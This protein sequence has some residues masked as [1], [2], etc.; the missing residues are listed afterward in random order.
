V[1]IYGYPKADGYLLKI[2]P[3]EADTVIRI[4]SLFGEHGYSAKKIVNILNKELKETGHPKPPRGQ[5][6]CVSSLLGGRK[7][8]RGIL[9][10]EIYVGRYYWNRSASKRNPK[11]GKRKVFLKNN[12]KWIVSNRPELQ[13]VSHELWIKAKDRQKFSQQRTAGQ[14]TK[15]KSLYT[16]NLFTGLLKCKECGGNIVVVSGGKHSKACGCSNNWNKGE[17][18]C[19][20]NIKMK[21][22]AVETAIF[23]ILNLDLA[24]EHI[25]EVLYKKINSIIMEKSGR[26]N[27]SWKHG[28][29]SE[30]IKRLDK[31]I[32]NYVSAIRAG[33]ISNIVRK[34]LEDAERLRASIEIEF[35]KSQKTSEGFPSISRDQILSYLTDLPRTLNLHPGFGKQFLSC[36][37]REILVIPSSGKWLFDLNLL[38]EKKDL[39]PFMK[40]PSSAYIPEIVTI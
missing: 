11:N 23:Q 19:S 12:S 36:L 30:Q 38:R 39:P 37:L 24:T 16:S 14:Y 8:F 32:L 6:W 17:S 29:L 21:K 25:I 33:F 26:L 40:I 3:D 9:N 31:E 28:S 22:T 1:D 27:P 34:Q 35:L 7:T 2:Q 15:G 4:F 10:N 18:V 5:Y 13:I 20:N